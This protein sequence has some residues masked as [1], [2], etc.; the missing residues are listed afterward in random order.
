MY[1]RMTRS[2]PKDT[3]SPADIER[4]M[5]GELVTSP[6]LKNSKIPRALDDIIL[7]ALHPDLALRYQSASELLED[8]LAARDKGPRKVGRRASAE[9]GTAQVAEIQSRLRARETPQPRFCWQCRKP[10]H[11]RADRCPFCSE[12]Q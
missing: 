9:P 12:A 11:A 4:L 3:P 5:R 1:Q 6:R 8:T 7:K 10:L 2:L